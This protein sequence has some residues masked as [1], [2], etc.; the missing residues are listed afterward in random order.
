MDKLPFPPIPCLF[1]FSSLFSLF[2]L[3]FPLFSL[4]FSLPR[5]LLLF[6]IPNLIQRFRFSLFQLIDWVEWFLVLIFRFFLYFRILRKSLLSNFVYFLR[7]QLK[8]EGMKVSSIF[9]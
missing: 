7:L 4:Q 3:F 5:L 9:L 2:S 1:A 6:P 8:A